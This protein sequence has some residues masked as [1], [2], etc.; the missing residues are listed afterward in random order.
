MKYRIIENKNGI[1]VER[2]VESLGGLI[3]SWIPIYRHD[4]V[5][6]RYGKLK[7]SEYKNPFKSK[8]QAEKWIEKKKIA[9]DETKD[10][11]N[12]FTIHNY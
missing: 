10:L 6:F 7:I 12:N 9:E 1:Y 4:S 3:W 5:M 8:R 11:D 2:C